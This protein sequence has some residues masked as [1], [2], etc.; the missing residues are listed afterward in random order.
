MPLANRAVASIVVQPLMYAAGTVARCLGLDLGEYHT[1]S[2]M[3]LAGVVLAVLCSSLAAAA[4][5]LWCAALL[6]RSIV[7]GAYHDSA[8]KRLSFLCGMFIGAGPGG[9]FWSAGYS[10]S[11]HS[12]L[13][14][15]GLWLLERQSYQYDEQ[16]YK[17]SMGGH[18]TSKNTRWFITPAE[19]C[20]C[21]AFTLAAAARSN[22]ILLAGF[23]LVHGASR[24]A[25]EDKDRDQ[26]QVIRSMHRCSSIRSLAYRLMS[27]VMLLLASLAIAL[28]SI[29]LQWHAVLS[30]CSHPPL[31]AIRWLGP[32][33]QWLDHA[34]PTA[35][36]LPLAAYPMPLLAAA[37][38]E[39]AEWREVEG[40]ASDPS[41]CLTPGTG[42]GIG[43]GFMPPPVY[44][45]I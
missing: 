44:T 34:V 22:G 1:E 7:G 8:V 12:M 43:L 27:R 39:S 30:L 4:A 33:F 3:A 32:A 45:S 31:N 41:W 5:E 6:S 19:I 10:G 21:F 15:L 23:L 20:A 16:G 35:L 14:C 24:L 37:G 29:L 28:P 9:V 26:S 38:T 18:V 2:I 11:L 13:A 42:T 17:E 36:P 40:G 25:I